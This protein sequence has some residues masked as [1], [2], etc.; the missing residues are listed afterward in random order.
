MQ[1]GQTGQDPY[2]TAAAGHQIP[3][4][5][6]SR[7]QPRL[8]R[9][10]ARVPEEARPE[11]RLARNVTTRGCCPAQRLLPQ[12]HNAVPVE[13]IREQIGKARVSAERKAASPAS[14]KSPGSFVAR[15]RL[16]AGV[17]STQSQTSRRASSCPTAV[18]PDPMN[19]TRNTA[20][21]P[22]AT[23]MALENKASSAFG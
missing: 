10:A 9:S 11:K 12:R 22:M 2:A 17:R 20:R 15:A 13:S 5:C 4:R 16:D 3:I 21:A 7:S 23:P 1:A 18:L 6:R 19:P 14:E 8:A